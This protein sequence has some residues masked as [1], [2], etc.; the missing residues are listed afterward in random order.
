MPQIVSPINLESQMIVG[1][2]HF[3][4]HCVL[5][6][7]LVLHFVCAKQ[8][9]IIWIETSCFSIGTPAAIHVMARKIPPKLSNAVTHKSDYWAL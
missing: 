4:G 5:Q 3:M 8:D 7:S 6:V 2:D 9:T 1:M